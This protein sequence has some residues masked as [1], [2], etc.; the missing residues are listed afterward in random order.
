MFSFHT[1]NVDGDSV[2]S[3]IAV[4]D[5]FSGTGTI[6]F[7]TYIERMFITV[8]NLGIFLLFYYLVIRQKSEIESLLLILYL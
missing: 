5:Q 8:I 6:D 2:L 3:M 1:K 4:W 7:L